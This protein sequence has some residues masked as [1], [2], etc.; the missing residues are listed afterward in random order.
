MAILRRS[1]SGFTLIEILVAMGIFAL[2]FSLVY[3]NFQRSNQQTS[4]QRETSFLMSRIR[5][6]QELTAAGKDA[7]FCHHWTGVSAD[8]A[9]SCT[10]LDYAYPCPGTDPTKDCS[11]VSPAPPGGFGLTFSCPVPSTAKWS[12]YFLT[13]QWPVMANAKSSYYMLAERQTCYNV[14]DGDT[15]AECFPFWYVTAD[16][17][18]LLPYDGILS[19]EVIDL[20]SFVGKGDTFQTK[21]TVSD[22]TS[23]VDLQVTD[24][25]SDSFHCGDESPWQSKFVPA[26]NFTTKQQLNKWSLVTTSTENVFNYP[27]QVAMRFVPPD[28]RTIAISDNISPFLPGTPSASTPNGWNLDFANPWAKVEIMLGLKNRHT[29]CQVVRVTREGTIN[30]YVDANCTFAD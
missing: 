30:S 19:A 26:Y 28:G 12:N 20:D 22:D 23:I 10:G 18:G 13:A 1:P 5:Y 25:N 16:D 21:Y 6:T 24:T 4:L 11:T 27:I 3:A 2:L 14:A 7:P 29:D 15:D 17:D 8:P 9:S